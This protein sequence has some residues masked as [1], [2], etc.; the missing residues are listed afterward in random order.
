[1]LVNTLSN[2]DIW[3][4]GLNKNNQVKVSKYKNATR[5]KL[6]NRYITVY[7]P[8]ISEEGKPSF[9]GLLLEFV[10][11]DKKNMSRDRVVQK[12]DTSLVVREKGVVTTTINI[13]TEAAIGLMHI[14][15][16]QFGNGK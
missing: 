1:M 8:I 13:T 10:V 12:T 14:L 4:F 3:I 16:I 15:K 7:H 2:L 5:V 6:H 9:E 11:L